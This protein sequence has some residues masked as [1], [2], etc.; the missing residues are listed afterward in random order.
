M[1]LNHRYRIIKD[2]AEGSFGKTF[3]AE[4]TQ[5][6]SARRCVIKQ[7]KP[8]ND[9]RPGVVQLIQERF[10]REAAVLEGV[11]RGHS[12][13]PDLLAYFQVDEQFY[14]VQEAV[15]G[16]PLSELTDLPWPEAKV[17]KLVESALGAIAHIH[18]QNIIH[19]DIKPDNII[20]RRTDNL[21]CLI[22]FGAVKELMN[23]TVSP[24][25]SL[26]P[27]PASSIVI[28]TLGFMSPEQAAGR[29]MFSSD[30]YSLSMTA[31]YLLTGLLPLEI[32]TN[33][34]NGR[35]LWK[36]FAP[37][38]S[39]R[40]AGILTRAIHPHPP[41][42]YASAPEMLAVLT[43]T[44]APIRPSPPIIPK[45]ET[46]TSDLPN[47]DTTNPDTT[48]PPKDPATTEI[49]APTPVP[50]AKRGLNIKRFLS[51]PRPLMYAAA[52]MSTLLVGGALFMG[53]RTFS[54]AVAEV[55]ASSPESLGKA[56]T[57]LEKR[58][59]A[60]PKDEEARFKLI[61]A[62]QTAGDYDEATEQID[63][64]LD[65]NEENTEALLQKGRMEM[66]E[67]DYAEAEDL[68]S[69][70]ME[71]DDEHVD[72]TNMLGRVY[73]ETGQYESAL[74]QFEKVVKLGD[75]NGLGYIN[76]ATLYQLQ[77]NLEESL[78]N[79]NLAVDSANAETL[80]NIYLG[81]SNILLEMGDAE[82]AAEDWESILS[83]SSQTPSDYIVKAYAEGAQNNSRAA[84]DYVEQALSIN[85]N[86]TGGYIAKAFVH[87]LD[88]KPQEAIAATDR[89]LEI[90]PRLV[91]A[92]KVKVDA[93]IVLPEPD[94]SAAVEVATRALSINPN[95]PYVLSQRCVLYFVSNQYDKAIPDC[96]KSIDT[97]PRI[98]EPYRGRGQS[99]FA[100][101]DY[102]KAEPDLTNYIE[103]NDELERPQ[104]P[105]IYAARAVIRI[106]KEDRDGAIADFTEAIALNP[107]EAQYY[108]LRG[109]LQLL[110]ENPEAAAKDLRKA[111][112]LL[113]EKGESSKELDALLESME[114]NGLI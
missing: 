89:A 24:S 15:E 42:R 71:L 22:D 90:S 103:L 50:I 77:G 93:M 48:A 110:S 95:T 13:I 68:F 91:D 73:Y 113:T 92:M 28:G 8:V 54:G 14:L 2:L 40:F 98:P 6:P 108:Q 26:T 99:Y 18:S 38:V 44:P 35:L 59:D 96:T 56:I 61:T 12:Q 36:Q 78:E 58:V 104:D 105:S 1:L 31:I 83:F 80:F 66:V 39:D 60:R 65:D 27:V 74:E 101:D 69:Q 3:L 25:G 64:L 53:V 100:K 17:S 5:M 19:R 62:Y 82:A 34:L 57:S 47:P 106:T 102:D 114:Q 30:L 87:L 46:V 84:M 70:V 63:E 45:S 107:N 10:A 33:S 67:G 72:A 55:D 52:G 88:Q 109:T 79:A 97:N 37:E 32:P 9:D 7:L 21:P 23:A 4:D 29:P 85:P 94:A 16:I 11:G 20:L 41:T 49:T 76:I 43:D 51:L 75:D 81:R 112:E 86:S 111:S